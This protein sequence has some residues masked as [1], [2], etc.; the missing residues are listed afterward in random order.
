M[1]LYE[2]SG[3]IKDNEYIT[4]VEESE[5]TAVDRSSICFINNKR[6]S[7]QIP[8]SYLEVYYTGMLSSD[9]H[10][11]HIYTTKLGYIDQYKENIKVKIISYLTD[12]IKEYNQLLK[13]FEV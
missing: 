6:I 3:F 7:I 11:I 13:C 9:K 1:K 12:T 4:Q 10:E 2:I 5:V 8:I